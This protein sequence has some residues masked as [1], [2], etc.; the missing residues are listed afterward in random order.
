[1]QTAPT[2]NPL[3][4]WK[5]PRIQK[6]KMNPEWKKKQNAGEVLKTKMSKKDLHPQNIIPQMRT[7]YP[8]PEEP[9]AE[10]QNWWI[11]ST[12]LLFDQG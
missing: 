3:P 1:M 4:V 10:K 12:I 9:T 2:Q 11:L 5:D 6:R 8:Q 7:T